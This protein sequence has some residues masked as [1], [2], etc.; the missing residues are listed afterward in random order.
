M[1]A[2]VTRCHVAH[3]RERPPDRC[4]RLISALICT[5]NASALN[6]EDGSVQRSHDSC[7]D[8]SIEELASAQ[9]LLNRRDMTV[10]VICLSRIPASLIGSMQSS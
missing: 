10:A 2:Y 4:V 8:D 1:H 7:R 9:H 5:F 3:F 6:C